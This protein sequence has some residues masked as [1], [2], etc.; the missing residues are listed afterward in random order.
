[1]PKRSGKIKVVFA[2]GGTGG[3]V[4]PLFA[5]AEAL[6][7]ALR[8][9]GVEFLLLGSA[10]G[11]QAEL[12]KA[13]G[14]AFKAIAAGKLRRYFSLRTVLAPFES[15]YGFFQARKAIRAFRAD[16]V[17]GAGGFASVP[18]GYAAWTLGVPLLIHQQDIEPSLSNRLLLP[19]SD[20]L[21][22]GF[23]I[24][25]HGFPLPGGNY[26]AIQMWE[27]RRAWTGNP[28]KKAFR[29]IPRNR[30]DAAI[31]AEARAAFGI[32][33]DWPVLLV[34]G[35][36]IG[37]AGL[38]A[39]LRD[40]L[41]ELCQ[42]FEVIHS[43]GAGKRV[44]FENPRY[45]QFEFITDM[46]AAYAIAD[47]ILSRAG[48]G[49]ITE[50]SAAGLPA[51]IVPMPDSHQ[52]ENALYLHEKDA[53]EIYAQQLLDAK[54]LVYILVGLLYDGDRRAGLSRNIS[55]IMPHDAAER[56][57]AIIIELCTR[58]TK[59]PAQTSASEK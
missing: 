18:A 57:S 41:P 43:S 2:G 7:Q 30:S 38:N 13:N 14:I 59:T 15:L 44:D 6:R 8:D 49:A 48:V 3:P 47:V 20:M 26:D 29:D 12:A 35:G 40:A 4:A 25:L 21:T 53:A 28:V 45:H 5:I 46:P 34:T 50:I 32:H 31:G 19:V 37:A 58:P 16:I 23:E 33:G 1:M 52:E 42:R 9:A 17:I 54:R 55:E 51:V 24:S 10:E 27:K 36:G 11:P 22:T 39:I 56:I